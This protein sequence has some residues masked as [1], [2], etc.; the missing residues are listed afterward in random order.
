VVATNHHVNAHDRTENLGMFFHPR[1]G[2]EV[3]RDRA[4]IF[5][6]GHNA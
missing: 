3:R 2:S 6:R 5:C 1:E 4:A